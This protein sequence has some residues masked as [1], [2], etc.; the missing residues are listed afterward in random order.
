[1][2]DP[3]FHPATKGMKKLSQLKIF[4]EGSMLKVEAEEFAKRIAHPAIFDTVR[5]PLLVLDD[6]FQVI[7]ASALFYR[8]FDESAENVL[9]RSLFLTVPLY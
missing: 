7:R 6:E 5:E 4:Q 2:D 8:V 3:R 1:V 9:G